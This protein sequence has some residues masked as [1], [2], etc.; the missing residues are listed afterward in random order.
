MLTFLVSFTNSWSLSFQHVDGI[1][2]YTL[3]KRYGCGCITPSKQIV[4]FVVFLCRLNIKIMK[5]LKR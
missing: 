3:N 4:I 2:S 1:G 5:K